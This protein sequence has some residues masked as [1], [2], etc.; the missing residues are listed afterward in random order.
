MQQVPGSND[1]HMHFSYSQY[2]KVFKPMKDTFQ[3]WGENS[4]VKLYQQAMEARFKSP[5]L[6]KTDMLFNVLFPKFP[7]EKN[8][9][10][11]QKTKQNTATV[12]KCSVCLPNPCHIQVYT[13]FHF[14]IKPN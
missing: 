3:H 6:G 4:K 11:N 9:Q 2:L 13:L 8:P 5:I 14:L 12:S 10:K 7:L 1:A